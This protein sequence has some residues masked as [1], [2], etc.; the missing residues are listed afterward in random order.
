MTRSA[1]EAMNASR[2]PDGWDEERVQHVL[3]YYEEQSDDEAVAEDD[4]AFEV[5]TH[6]AMA[7]PVELVS[8]VR[9]LIAKR[10]LQ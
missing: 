9:D 6:T 5:P 2:Y 10:G 4:A 8:E 3:R 1:D 7:V